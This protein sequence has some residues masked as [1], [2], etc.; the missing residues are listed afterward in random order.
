MSGVFNQIHYLGCCMNRL[1][2]KKRENYSPYNPGFHC[3]SPVLYKCTSLFFKCIYLIL[4]TSVT[5]TC[6]CSGWGALH[7]GAIPI[8]PEGWRQGFSCPRLARQ[9]HDS[10]FSEKSVFFPSHGAW[11]ICTQ[12]GTCVQ[13]LQICVWISWYQS[14]YHNHKG[15]EPSAA[16]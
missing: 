7:S 11:R 5:W 2:T 10:D 1:V 3:H 12:G 9:I 14:C 4:K 15:L 8:L 13:K 6:L 16:C